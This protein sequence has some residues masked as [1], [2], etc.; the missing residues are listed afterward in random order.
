M[1][2]KTL[3]N[4]VV[5]ICIFLFFYILNSSN[6]VKFVIQDINKGF[7]GVIVDKYTVRQGVY[8]TFLKVRSQ[9]EILDISPSSQIMHFA[10]IGDSIIKVKGENI[11]YIIKG[12]D[13]SKEFFYVSISKE[14]R[15]NKSFPSQWKNKWM[16]ATFILDSVYNAR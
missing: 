12:N 1:R 6:P 8:P 14:Q 4:V 7:K 9:N 16:G 11:C 3:I 15:E 5:G 10:E 13:I 2:K